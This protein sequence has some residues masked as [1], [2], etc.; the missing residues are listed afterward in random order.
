MKLTAYQRNAARWMDSRRVSLLLWRR[1]AGKS[2]LFSFKILKIMLENPGILCTF[3]S[4]SLAVGSEIPFKTSQIFAE[5]LKALRA[6]AAGSGLDIS[7]NGEGLDDPDLVS[8]FKQGRLEVSFKHSAL[9]SS[10]L[11]VIAP[12]AATARGYTGF[13]FMDEIGF[14][15]DFKTLFEAMEPII[16]R[17]PSFHLCMAT[18]PPKDDA[19][20][21]YELAAPEPGTDTFAP[22]PKGHFYTSQA[23]IPVHRVD[24]WDA[25]LAG[26]PLYDL[27]QGKPVTPEQHRAAALDR[28]AWDRNYALKWL[29][30]STS[31]LS[32]SGLAAARDWGARI[33]C[34][35]ADGDLPV[36]WEENMAPGM[37]WAI[38]YDI[39]TT[40]NG[41]S[42][43]SSIT[44]TQ[45]I[46]PHQY[47]ERLDFRFKADSPDLA[48]AYLAIIIEAGIRR[49][50]LRPKAAALDAT[51]ERYYCADVRKE[52]S[53]F[54]RI[55]LVVSSESTTWRGEKMSYKAFLGNLYANT[56]DDSAIA[57]PPDRWLSDDRRL[58][59][60]VKGSFDNELDSAGNHGDTFDS[61]K[62]AR[63]AID[64]AS[65][66]PVE[67]AAVP[68]GHPPLPAASFST[69][70][71]IF[72]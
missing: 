12:N 6:A 16:S 35:A 63:Y 53:R 37:P 17:D 46:G 8:L 5:L 44:V 45:E 3:V 32:L 62:L 22:D 42:N 15:R 59:K 50:G 21:S 65:G 60:R 18:T 2:T 54:C 20:Y 30:G 57:I 33:G 61:G 24:A 7:S 70:R 28:D 67:A 55:L 11:R 36:G 49:T 10:R 69:R 39:A 31:A 40:T 43:P 72:G 29:Q 25:N 26:V 4:A 13:V 27:A 34:I 71:R 51:N 56:Y 64:S 41:T 66:A 52:F 58:A 1:Q 47:A 23:G 14:I 48:K 38:G 68:I 9:V 19:H